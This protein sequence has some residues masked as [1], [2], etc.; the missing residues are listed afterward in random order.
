MSFRIHATNIKGAGATHVV[1]SI[2]DGFQNIDDIEIVECFVPSGKNLIQEK[3]SEVCSAVVAHNRYLPNLVSR[4]VECLCSNYFFPTNLPM[5]V[6]G[7]IPLNFRGDQYLFVQTTKMLKPKKFSLKFGELK[8]M[9]SRTI[10]KMNHKKVKVFFVQTFNMKHSLIQ[11]YQIEPSK[12]EVIRQPPPTWIMNNLKLRQTDGAP[13]K[14][15]LRL[16]FP[17]S[18][19][20]HKNHKVLQ[21]IDFGLDWP[22]DKIVLTIDKA[23][24]QGLDETVIQCV[25]FLDTELVIEEYKKADALLFLSSEESLGLPIIEAIFLGLPIICPD[26]PY[27]RELCGSNAYYFELNSLESLKDAIY[28]LKVDLNNNVTKSFTDEVKLFPNNWVDVASKM[29][30]H[31]D[32]QNVQP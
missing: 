20:A 3:C 26:L 12:I 23:L 29:I 27:S 1:T 11:S 9:V 16:F 32:N 7:D 30:K 18:Y 31:I 2:L 21:D 15:K 5:L 25:G 10:F 13:N 4:V 19:Y 17:S 22:V 24:L 28:R 6:L 14:E 8:Y